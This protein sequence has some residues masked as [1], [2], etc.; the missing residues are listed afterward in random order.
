MSQIQIRKSGMTDILL[1]AS[2]WLKTHDINA[3]LDQNEHVVGWKMIG[4]NEALL[5]D[6][7]TK[8]SVEE[9][10]D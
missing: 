9:G 5:L 1:Y 10:G 8:K 7:E 2:A 4:D 6:I 3:F